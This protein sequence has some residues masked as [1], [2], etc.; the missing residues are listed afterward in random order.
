[1]FKDSKPHGFGIYR[2][3]DGQKYT[4]HWLNGDKTHGK[5]IKV[6]S[7]TYTGHFTND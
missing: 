3:A 5:D 4:G 2:H 7:K 6:D 1:M